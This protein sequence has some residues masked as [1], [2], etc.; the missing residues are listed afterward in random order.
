MKEADPAD[1]CRDRSFVILETENDQ[2]KE[3][4]QD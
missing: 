3:G 2:L 1:F 4:Q